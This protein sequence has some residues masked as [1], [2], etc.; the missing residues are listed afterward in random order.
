[1]EKVECLEN[2]LLK[3]YLWNL[4]KKSRRVLFILDNWF[5]F[6]IKLLKQKLVK[7]NGKMHNTSNLQ[8]IIYLFNAPT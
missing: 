1:M 2:L 5:L 7:K 3:L 4:W 6:I 8:W